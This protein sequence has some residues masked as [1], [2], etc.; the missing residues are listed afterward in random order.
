MRVIMVGRLLLLLEA[1]SSSG[2]C[3]T[4]TS[5]V[6]FEIELQFLLQPLVEK[7]NREVYQLRTCTT[8]CEAGR[9]NTWL[10]L[11]SVKVVTLFQIQVMSAV[12][13]AEWI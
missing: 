11:A 13:S 3:S 2:T 12:L 4:S 6:A 9:R 1:C 10:Q 5:V 7:R 8:A